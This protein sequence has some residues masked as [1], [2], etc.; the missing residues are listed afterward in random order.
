MLFPDIDLALPHLG[1]TPSIT[2]TTPPSR[3]PSGMQPRV[4]DAAY[5][6]AVR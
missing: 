6:L 2:T 5:G 3:L 1:V 4:P